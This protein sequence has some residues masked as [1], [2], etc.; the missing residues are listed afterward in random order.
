MT[1]S[2]I[3]LVLNRETNRTEPSSTDQ[4]TAPRSLSNASNGSIVN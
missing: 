4:N 2:I 3:V 1:F